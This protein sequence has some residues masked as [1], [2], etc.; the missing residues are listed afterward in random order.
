[1]TM[2]R[3]LILL[4]VSL[5]GCAKWYIQDGYVEAVHAK[6]KKLARPLAREI[7]FVYFEDV[8]QGKKVYG[9]GTTMKQIKAQSYQLPSATVTV[10]ASQI[11]QASADRHFDAARK[12]S[13]ASRKAHRDAGIQASQASEAALQREMAA[14]RAA[15]GAD[16]A[17]ATAGLLAALGG[18]LL[19]AEERSDAEAAVRDAVEVTGAIGDEAPKGS[20]MRVEMT[21]TFKKLKKGELGKQGGVCGVVLSLEHPGGKV[22]RVTK[23]Y[24]H[25]THSG[26]A[27]PGYSGWEFAPNVTGLWFS[28]YMN[29]TSAVARQAIH[30]LDRVVRTARG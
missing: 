7:K 17:I 3:T 15:A 10:R 14:E 24:R 8:G 22:Y 16:L 2:R 20:V 27:P 11:H 21:F 5:T 25:L 1:M 26:S 12:S 6:P 18:P 28:M 9:D 4:L 13:G 23:A 30:D 19:Q 29:A